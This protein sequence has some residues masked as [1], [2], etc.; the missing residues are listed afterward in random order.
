MKMIKQEWEES[1]F[2]LA[3][4]QKSNIWLTV[5][6][7]KGFINYINTYALYSRYIDIYSLNFTSTML[8]SRQNQMILVQLTA[9][10]M[11][12]LHIY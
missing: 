4:S 3:V 10:K 12:I 5:A 6:F 8:V 2:L 9:T 7:V 11:Y 1:A